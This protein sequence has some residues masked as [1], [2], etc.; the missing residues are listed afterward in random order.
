VICEWSSTNRRTGD[1]GKVIPY[2][3][4]KVQLGTDR[5][6]D[7]ITSCVVRWEPGRPPQ[8]AREKARPRTDDILEAAIKAA[9][10]RDN[11]SK[12]R[13]AFYELHG[14]KANAIRQAWKRA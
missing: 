11:A 6:G 7:P 5:D 12:V 2:R 8:A 13:A 14:G 1:V 10:G 9:G 3:L 4:E